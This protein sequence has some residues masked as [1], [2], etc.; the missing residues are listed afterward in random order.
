M[1]QEFHLHAQ[2]LNQLPS[3]RDLSEYSGEQLT[4]LAEAIEH[5]YKLCKVQSEVY[6]ALRN[7]AEI[8]DHVHKISVLARAR[9]KDGGLSNARVAV[10]KED[11]KS[12]LKLL[13][14]LAE[15]DDGS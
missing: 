3:V 2:K 6:D 1:Q 8:L 15:R 4:T 12:G 11:C 5:D 14:S 13:K 7:D 10:H 9:E